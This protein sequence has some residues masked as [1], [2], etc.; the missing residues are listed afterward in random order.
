MYTVVHVSKGLANKYADRT[1]E[2]IDRY[3]MEHQNI[4][5]FKD[6]VREP[7]IYNKT[8]DSSS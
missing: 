4:L 6:K 1:L 8:V 3:F 5:V 7:P 2:D